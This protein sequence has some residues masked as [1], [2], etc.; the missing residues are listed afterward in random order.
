MTNHGLCTLQI[1]SDHRGQAIQIKFPIHW[2]RE[3]ACFL[4]MV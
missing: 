1:C 4:D 2:G 3:H